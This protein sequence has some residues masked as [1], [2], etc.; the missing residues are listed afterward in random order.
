MDAMARTKRQ[1][2]GGGRL[3]R[4]MLDFNGDE[5][6]AVLTAKEYPTLAKV[7]NNE[8]DAIFDSAP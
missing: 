2:G 5:P 3:R 8:D 7:W 4:G 6:E 1:A